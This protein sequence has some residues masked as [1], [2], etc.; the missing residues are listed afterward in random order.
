MKKHCFKCFNMKIKN[1]KMWCK[2]GILKKGKLIPYRNNSY[3]N[4]MF[5]IANKCEQYD[6]VDN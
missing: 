4:K 2:F 3:K 5:L 6:D 1:L